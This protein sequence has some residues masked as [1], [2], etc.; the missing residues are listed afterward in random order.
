MREHTYDT[1]CEGQEYTWRN[2]KYT[3]EGVYADTVANASA[4]ESAIYTLSLE[5]VR[6]TFVTTAK[7]GEICADDREFSIEFTYS[8]EKPTT[9]S[10]LFDQLAKDE[11]FV[12]VINKPFLGEDR[13]AYGNVPAKTEVIYLEHTTYVKPNRYSMSLVL[14]NGVCGIS[15]SNDVELL[16][17]YP[18][19]IIEQN[20]NDIVVPIKQEWNG[21]LCILLC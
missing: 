6:P 15:R 18:S 5:V 20:W 7:G 4:F 19:W 14:D 17:K 9:Y 8:G 11:G 16:V 1:I 12:D 10:I 13:L 3:Q 21:G 2:K